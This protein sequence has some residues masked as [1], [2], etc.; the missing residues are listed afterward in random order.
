MARH[1]HTL[2]LFSQYWGNFSGGKPLEEGKK[3]EMKW[4]KIDHQRK[5]G[6]GNDVKS[7][8]MKI[9]WRQLLWH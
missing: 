1:C 5:S 4:E 3:V 7:D 6:T 2:K 9:N 8:I